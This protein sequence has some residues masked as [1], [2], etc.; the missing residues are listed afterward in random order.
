MTG[1][2]I[3]VYHFFLQRLFETFFGPINNQQLIQR[4]YLRCMQ[5]YVG[6]HV[7][8]A[9]LVSDFNPNWNVLQSLVES[10]TKNFTEICS[11]ATESLQKDRYTRR[12]DE[13]TTKQI[14]ATFCCEHTKNEQ[15]NGNVV[16]RYCC[17]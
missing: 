11:A 6:L 17:I 3:S 16:R 8:Y 10:P 1:Y 5:K 13:A 2:K 7:K 14:F 12:H 9:L 15:E 4:L